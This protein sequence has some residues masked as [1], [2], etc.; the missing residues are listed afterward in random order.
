VRDTLAPSLQQKIAQQ[1]RKQ[2]GSNEVMAGQPA[3][4]ITVSASSPVGAQAAQVQ[5]TV[6]VAGAATAYNRSIVEHTAMQLL[7]KQAAQ[8]LDRA[9]HL[10]GAPVVTSAP[11]VQQGKGGILYLSVPV[12]GLWVYD[13]TQQQMAGWRQSIRGA[14]PA[15]ALAYLNAQPGVAGVEIHLPFGTDHLPTD[16]NEIQVTLVRA[17]TT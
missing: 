17:N 9:Y 5:V 8:T 2:I 16:I 13:L 15:V 4:N 10:Q 14:T 7:S 1:L 12:S 3:Y 11:T 6:K